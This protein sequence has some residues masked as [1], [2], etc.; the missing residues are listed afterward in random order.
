MAID[1]DKLR[2]QIRLQPQ[3]RKTA[4][5]CDDYYHGKQITPDVAA[6]LAE[7]GQPNIVVNIIKPTVNA[8][9][10]LEAKQR[11]DWRVV[12]DKNEDQEAAE[13]LS[14]KLMEAER[15][16]RADNA[17]SEA[18][19][20]QVKSGLGW[21]EVGRAYN[22]F[23]Y[24]YRVESV[25]YREIWWDWTARKAD[26]SDAGWLIRER[27]YPVKALVEF[28]PEHADL[29]KACGAGWD[30]T[31]REVAVESETLQ[32]A[33]DRERK[34]SW[35]D[36]EW[37]NTEAGLVMLREVWERSFR[38]GTVITLPT[39]RVVELD[40]KNEIHMLAIAA[41]AAQPREAVIPV[42]S[43]AMF[44][45]PHKLQEMETNLRNFPYVPFWGYKEEGSGIPYGIVRDMLP[46]QDEV[47]ARRRKL[48]WLLSSKRV[49]A[50][51]DALDHQYNDLSDLANE[52]S[53]PDAV[54]ITNPNRKNANAISYETDVGL[55]SQQFDIMRDSEDAIQRVAGIY[56]TMMGRADKATSGTAIAGLVEQGQTSVADIN[57]NY[58]F[59][60][61]RVGELLL[62][63]LIEDIG[64][65]TD[66][67]VTIDKKRNI[68]LNSPT[69]D[70]MTGY[71]YKTNDITRATLKVAL[72]DIPS[73]PA[74]PPQQMVQIAEV[75]KSLPPQLQ[76]L[77]VPYYLESTDLPK[78]EEMS[79]LIRKQLGIEDPNGENQIP[80]EVQQQ[81]MQAQ[82]MLEQQGAQMQ[83]LAADN[84]R[85]KSGQDV[86]MAEI[87]IKRDELA[88]DRDRFNFEKLA[89]AADMTLK[90]RSQA[91]KNQ[92]TPA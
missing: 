36:D 18:Y 75:L 48:M 45:G 22:P 8:L 34:T 38:R 81:M 32:G 68:T 84:E 73:P 50:D 74:Y 71:E 4:G 92:G 19:G 27:W 23:E 43:V 60:R 3:W 21:V 44:V 7:R 16:S 85:L 65:Q 10:G 77:L 12:A 46:L 37:R 26:L 59:A 88:L 86:K 55:A 2:D 24:P 51:S 80:P 11:T 35:M 25:N 56:N 54:I 61:A 83:Q 63:L 39:G 64:Q 1:I 49:I 9:L 42:L 52:V 70:P 79:E 28:F 72:A 69:I 33:Y 82:V 87:G 29:L 78:R 17:I 90:G 89:R 40:T 30:S 76:A 62:D 41:G 20:Q 58:R 6:E 53:R 91:A 66:V 57:D 14:V 13:G 67:L 47:N 15:E 31:W 5:V